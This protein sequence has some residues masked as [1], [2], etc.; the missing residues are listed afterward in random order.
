MKW[1]AQYNC[2]KATVAKNAITLCAN[3]RSVRGGGENETGYFV[4]VNGRSLR[5]PFRDIEAA[6]EA[7]VRLALK[8][9]AEASEE[10]S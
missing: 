6:K 9:I 4:N 3:W 10:L 8:I 2:Y 1:T 5:E 7:A